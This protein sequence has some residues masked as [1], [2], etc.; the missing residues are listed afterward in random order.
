MT[1]TISTGGAT[2]QRLSTD[3]CVI[4]AGA[5]GLSVAASAALLG[6]P[7]VL[8]ER[9]AMGGECLN[10]GCVPSKALIA[11]AG[12]AKADQRAE[13]FGV[14]FSAPLIDRARIGRHIR[15]VIASIAPVDSAERYRAMGAEVITGEARFVDARTVAVGETLVTARRFVIATGAGPMLPAIPGLDQTPFLTN[16]TIFNLDSVPSRLAIIGGGPVGVE[17]AQAHRRLGADVTLIEAGRLLPR[18]DTDAVHHLRLALER[19]GVRLIEGARVSAVRPVSSGVALDLVGEG[20]PPLLQAS[21]LLI[22]TGRTPRLDALDLGKTGVSATADGIT[23]DKHLKTANRRIYAIGDCVAGAPRFT[24]VANYQA[25][26]VIRNALFR[27]P[28]RVD[29]VSIPRVVYTDPEIATVGLGE[30][31]A[32]SARRG[33]RALR[34][35]FSENDRARAMHHPEGFVKILIDGRGRILGATI[36]G[37]GAGEMIAPFA[38]A[39]RQ[40]L[41][42]GAIYDLILPYPTLSEAARRAALSAL[43]PQLRSPW[44]GRI[45]RFLRMFG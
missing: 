28:I 44:P 42:I 45:I 25:G 19:E 4:G 39:L 32:R 34:W 21:H 35:P 41:K 43:A 31:E 15:A 30:E 11:A 6:V 33:V 23:V 37:H 29:Y 16:E 18:E 7:V 1:E 9:G 5:A 26:L 10:A 12:M 20:A 38:L 3:L 40:K 14:H 2:P 36:V 22:A 8:I 27:L 17:L 24:H 13:A